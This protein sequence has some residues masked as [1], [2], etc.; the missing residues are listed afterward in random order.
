MDR[1]KT[2]AFLDRFTGFASGATTMAL[3]VVA[4][5]SGLLEWLARNQTGTAQEIADGARLQTRY[6]REI[7][8]GLAAA[9]AVD[10]DPD[11]RTFTLPPEHALF[12]ADE[13]SPYFMGGWFDMLPA[14]MAQVE[15]VTQAT[16]EGGGVSF[17]EFGV[18]MVRGIDRG[19]TPSQ[20][21]FLTQRWLPAVPGIVDRLT[22]GIRVADVGCGTGTAARLMAEA[23]PS[24]RVT[25]Y[26]I[27]PESLAVAR[28]RGTAP[29]LEFV[30]AGAE[31]IPVD[32]PFDLITSFDVIH[33]LAD[34]LAG[35]TRIR[36][37]LAVD[38]TYLMMEPNVSSHLEENLNDRGALLYGVS[39]LHCMT[40]SLAVGG[41]GLG[42]AW[43]REMAEDYARRAGFTTFTLLEEITNKFSAFYLLMP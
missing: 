26:D 6:V 37:A 18:D 35:L 38:G 3:L 22:A 15:G 12:L 29:N 5:R 34:P 25:G 43:G 21:V 36:E 8:S 40:Q 19:N 2:A 10:W 24:S 33:D 41:E 11:A 39:T 17:D 1:E 31:S 23:F 13:D 20:R 7:L 30:E 32:T 28:E 16:R 14:L 4:D 9:G 42:A 27:S